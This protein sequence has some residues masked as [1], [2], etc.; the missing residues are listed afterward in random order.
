L[1]YL[2]SNWCVIVYHS[3]IK[4]Y[5][6]TGLKCKKCYLL[7]SD[8]FGVLESVK[9]AADIYIPV[10]GVVTDVNSALED[11]PEL[12]NEDPYNKG[13]SILLIDYCLY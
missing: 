12:I 8:Q 9:A 11:Q 3:S 7:A 6:F 4:V 2:K 1:T 13:K 10:S 5:N